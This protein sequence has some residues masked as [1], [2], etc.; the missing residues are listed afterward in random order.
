MEIGGGGVTAK[1]GIGSSLFRKLY[2][3]NQLNMKSA[4]MV[5]NISARKKWKLVMKLNKTS[6][7]LLVEE[8]KGNKVGHSFLV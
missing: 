2:K 1:H 6:Y 5:V 4:I 8:R 3:W 7:A